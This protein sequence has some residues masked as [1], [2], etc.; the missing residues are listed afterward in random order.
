MI[1]VK[2]VATDNTSI[3]FFRAINEASR[4][5]KSAMIEETEK[6]KQQKLNE[7]RETAEK[8][9]EEYIFAAS[10]KIADNDGVET[11]QLSLNL[12][13]KVLGV[14]QEITDSV[15]ADVT[16][17]IKSFVLTDDYKKMLLAS[18][19]KMLGIC[20]GEELVIYLNSRD[21]KYADDIKALSDTIKIEADAKIAL[22]GI[23]G[24]CKERSVKLNDLLETRLSVL[25]EQFYENSGLSLNN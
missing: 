12:K 18:A 14:R 8:K 15:F 10:S 5:Q 2:T 9:Y 17:K 21:M 24:V 23:Y 6:L 19:E 3:A 20:K 25:R 1:E 4:E 16:E 7:A 13:K 22:G 11:E